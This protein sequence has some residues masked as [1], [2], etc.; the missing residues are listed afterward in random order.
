MHGRVF[1]S[2]RANHVARRGRLGEQLIDHVT[3][4]EH[5]TIVCLYYEPEGGRPV[6]WGDTVHA[7][8]GGVVTYEWVCVHYF[9]MKVTDF[10]IP[11]FERTWSM[12]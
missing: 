8:S 12:Q 4:E 3:C 5:W 2:P 10:A 11:L 9:N 7:E 1:S 6:I